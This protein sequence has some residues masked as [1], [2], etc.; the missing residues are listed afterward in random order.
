MVYIVSSTQNERN[1]QHKSVEVENA[2][3]IHAE[4]PIFIPSKLFSAN[5]PHFSSFLLKWNDCFFVREGR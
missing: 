3:E 5:F 2:K 4:K 1:L